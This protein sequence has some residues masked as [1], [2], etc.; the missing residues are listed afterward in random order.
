MPP[1]TARAIEDT[2][3]VREPEELEDPCDLLPIARRLEERLVL[4][5][6]ARVEMPLPPFAGC[7]RRRAGAPLRASPR[8]AQ[9]KTGS[10]YAPKTLSSASRISYSVA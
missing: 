6:V 10:R 1:L 3:P 9:K 4:V 2:G 5:Q 7:R 8:R